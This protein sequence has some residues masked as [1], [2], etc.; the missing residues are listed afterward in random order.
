MTKVSK[1]S[2]PNQVI[3]YQLGQISDLKKIN[4]PGMAS[5]LKKVQKNVYVCAY[6]LD[7]SDSIVLPIICPDAVLL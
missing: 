5:V 2:W 1:L 3:F 7:W 6:K 4:Y